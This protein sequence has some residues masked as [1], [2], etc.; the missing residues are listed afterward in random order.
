MITHVAVVWL[1]SAGRFFCFTWCWVEP[2]SSRGLIRLKDQGVQP[3]I[4]QH[5]LF[6]TQVSEGFLI[7]F[8]H[9]NWISLSLAVVS[10]RVLSKSKGQSWRYLKGQ[11]Q[12]SQ[13]TFCW[14]NKSQGKLRFKGRKNSP[15]LLIGKRDEDW[16]AKYKLPLSY[17]FKI[18]VLLPACV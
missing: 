2:K 5:D 12:R 15:H 1:G 18:I 4:W 13:A 3:C 6:I 16:T 14:W 11:L 10:K 9:V 8:L 17:L 7:W